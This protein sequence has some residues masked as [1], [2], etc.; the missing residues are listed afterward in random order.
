MQKHSVDLNQLKQLIKEFNDYF[1]SLN[2]CFV[3]REHVIQLMK[4]AVAQR[5]H[6]LVFG[7]PGTTKTAISDLAMSGIEGANKFYL[8]LSMFMTE[9]AVFGPYDPKKM[10]ED[11]VLIHRTENMLPESNFARL[12]EFLDPNMA[13]LRSLLGVLNERQLKR[14]RQILTVPLYTVYCDT[15][16]DPYQVLKNSPYLWAVL[17][18]ILFMTKVDYISDYKD[19]TEMITRFQTGQ[20]VSLDKKVSL[21][22]I[23][24]ISELIVIPPSLIR[25]QF[26]YQALGQA[27]IE[28]R[29]KRKQAMANNGENVILPDISDR[30]FAQATQMCEVSAVLNGRLECQ[31]EDMKDIYYAIGTTDWEKEI[32]LEIYEQK[33]EYV[34]ELMSQQVDHAQLVALVSVEKELENINKNDPEETLHTLAVIKGQLEPIIPENDQVNEKKQLLIDKL[35]ALVDEATTNLKEKIGLSS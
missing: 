15:N 23:D 22:V 2:K 7:A 3:N 14:G 35:N 21:S 5:Q 17:D 26:I 25:N 16:K 32:W 8:E 24:Q 27:F 10:R 12:G 18:R 28:Y 31:P 33:V 19:M 30:R 11:G 20:T 29:E 34:K 13:L 6:L 1:E 9:D 4:F